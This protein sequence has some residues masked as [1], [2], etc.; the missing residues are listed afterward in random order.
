MPTE[1]IEP[2]ASATAS[3]RQAAGESII[4]AEAGMIASR[5]DRGWRY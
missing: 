1:P 3:R 5:R 4:G 2:I